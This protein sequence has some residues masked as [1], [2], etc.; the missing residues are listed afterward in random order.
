VTLPLCSPAVATL[1]I[2]TFIGSWNDFLGPLIFMDSVRNYTL[3]VGI[4]LY[5]GSYY[6]DYGRT[7]ATSALSMAPLLIVFL[8]FQRKIIDSMA[9]AGMKD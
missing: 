4:A 1:A 9:T 5:Q 6:T 7:L 3:P 2:L 8:I